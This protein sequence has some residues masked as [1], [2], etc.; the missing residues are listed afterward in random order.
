[1][2]KRN[3]YRSLLATFV[4]NCLFI[5]PSTSKSEEVHELQKIEVSVARNKLPQ[6]ILPGSSTVIDSTQIAQKKYLNVEDLLRGELGLDVVQNGPTG[7]STTVF[8]RG[9]GSSSTLVL[10]DGVQVNSN[11]TG[12]FNFANILLDNIDRIEILRGPQSTLWGADAVGGVINLVTKKG[13]GKPTHRFTFEGGSFSTFKETL[14]SAGGFEDFDY[15]LSAS[16]IDT[17]GFS[18]ANESRGNTEDDGYENTSLSLRA[19]LYFLKDGRVDVIARYIDSRNEFDNFSGGPVDGPPFSLTESI[20]LSAPVLYSFTSWWEAKLTPSYAKE[21]LKSRQQNFPDSDIISTTYTV[22]LQNTFTIGE[23]FNLIAGGEYQNRK[24]ENKGSFEKV[25]ENKSGYMQ[26]VMNY[27]DQLV[28][29]AGFRYD[30]NNSFDNA[31]THKFEAAYSFKSIGTRIRAAQATGFRA[32][33]INDLFFP[34]F[35]NP[36][37][38]PEKSES[39]EAGFDQTLFDGAVTLS[40]V[41]FNQDF[42]NLIQFSFATFRP[43]NVAKANSKGVETS[44]H[45]ELPQN[46]VV[47]INHTWTD[48]FDLATKTRLRRRA[49]HKVQANI[50]HTW[51]KKLETL[52]GITHKS[53]IVDGSAGNTMPFVTVRGVVNYKVCESLNLFVRGENIFDE[54]YE[55]IVG[56]GTAGVSGYGGF[57]INF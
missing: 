41:Y 46:F 33:T 20:Y 23:Y 40:S 44:L 34:G 45:V 56:Y 32:P 43:E 12:A 55:E 4:L 31:F 2:C 1:M 22:D 16:R 24:G 15:A 13:K 19:G 6:E 18:S 11:T 27:E 54:E 3:I 8:M 7:A 49:K 50:S 21:D 38:A 42:E 53:G 48:A 47:N 25:L 35:S 39:W 26:A 37:L 52:I 28:L 36:D 30:G 17:E 10:I 29:T 14:S 51:N 5:S 9:A 57:N